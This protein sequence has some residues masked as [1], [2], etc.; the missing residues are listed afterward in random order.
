MVL[1]GIVGTLVKWRNG[2]RSGLRNQCQKW[3]VGSSPTL[4]TKTKDKMKRLMLLSFVWT[5]FL[6]GCDPQPKNEI[7]R[8]RSDGENKLTIVH[9][10]YGNTTTIYIKN[11]EDAKQYK[12]RLQQ[13]IKDIEEYERE[14]VPKDK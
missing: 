8:T 7:T 1:R 3:R 10:N 2:I 14:L 4:T 11:A 5:A 13:I 9:R 12:E 6:F